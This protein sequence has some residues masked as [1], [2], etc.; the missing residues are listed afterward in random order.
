MQNEKMDALVAEL[1]RKIPRDVVAQREGGR[2][3][4][5][6]YLE[7]HYVIDRLNQTIGHGFW[8]YGSTITKL[9]DGKVPGRNG[10]TNYV[11]YRADVRLAVKF[12]NGEVCEYGDVGFGDGQDA[13]NPGKA[14]ELAMKE[15][16]TDGLKR[17]ARVLGTSMGNGLYDKSGDGVEE[18]PPEKPAKPAEIKVDREKLNSVISATSRVVV[19]KGFMTVDSIKEAMYNKYKVRE[20]EALSDPQALEFK[21]FLE[22]KAKGA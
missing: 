10:D 12:P 22:T 6:D 7:G 21:L 5:L 2:G 14:H 8:S 19:A 3:K 16:V 15:A 13:L 18:A 9:Y 4:K 11:S 17:C 20:K 1:D